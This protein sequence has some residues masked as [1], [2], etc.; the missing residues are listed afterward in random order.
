MQAG[1][2]LLL[3]PSLSLWEVQRKAPL[4]QILR[5]SDVSLQQVLER[6]YSPV[7]VV[8]ESSKQVDYRLLLSLCPFL[9]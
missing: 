5:L 6:C 9:H 3:S 1:Y 7:H 8:L 4:L 2:R